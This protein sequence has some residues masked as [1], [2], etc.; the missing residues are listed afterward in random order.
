MARQSDDQRTVRMHLLPRSSLALPD[1]TH[2]RIQ[3]CRSLPDS[4]PPSSTTPTSRVVVEIPTGGLNT[5]AGR[6]SLNQTPRHPENRFTNE[7]TA[8]WKR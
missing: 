8:P 4:W 7:G 2:E 3:A 6:F 1:L 5:L